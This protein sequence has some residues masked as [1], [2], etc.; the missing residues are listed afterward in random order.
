MSVYR[1]VQKGAEHAGEFGWYIIVLAIGAAV[2]AFPVYFG[3][4]WIVVPL[5]FRQLPELSYVHCM[6]ATAG[7]G[8]LYAV[9]MAVKKGWKKLAKR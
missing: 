5:S 6:W 9:A 1:D 4:N 2:C 8:V 3:W 7:I